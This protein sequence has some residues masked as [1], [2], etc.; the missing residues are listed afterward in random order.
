MNSRERML[1]AINHQRP[2]RIPT[3]IWATPETWAK[4]RRHFGETADLR[5]ILHIDGFAWAAPKYI[6]PELPPVG[7]GE[8]INYWQ[9]RDKAIN[10][11]G[12]EYSETSQSPLA[13]AQTID[14]LEAFPWPRREWFDFSVM[15]EP[16]RQ[17]QQKQA[18]QVGYQAP[19]YYHNQLRGLEQS[20][21]DPLVD[22]EFTHHL[23]GRLTDSFLSIHR[24]MFEACGHLLDVTQVTDDYGMQTGPM[25]S[26]ETFGAFYKPCLKKMIDL[27]K[28]FGIKVFHHDDGAMRAFLPELIELGIDILN[29]VQWRCPGMECDGLKRDFG[30]KI[31]FHGG[32]DNQQTLPFGTASD[33]RKEVRAVIDA[34]AGD[35][36]GYIFAPCHNIQVVSPVEN[37]IAMYDEAWKYGKLQG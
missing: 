13:S 34:L 36:T 11:G 8:T 7:V 5:S 20:L 22:P 37:V 2:D 25:I 9:I 21:I 19:F 24:G 26:M 27:A 14:D 1:A 12:G 30:K 6:G 15:A 31:C 17:G 29:P 35:G 3:D 33:V 28:E 10:Y 32:I 18:T 4:L 16:L 23:L